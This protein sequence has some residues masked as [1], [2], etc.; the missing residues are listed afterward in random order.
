MATTGRA[1]YGAATARVSRS[2]PGGA[3]DGTPPE[4]FRAAGATWTRSLVRTA[5]A[6]AVGGPGA[7]LVPAVASLGQWTGIRALPGDACRWRGPRFPARIALT[8]DDGPHPDATPAVLD[9]LDDLG[10]RAT[11]F[12]VAAAA[13]RE[14]ELVAEIVRR[15]HAVGAHGYAHRS[16]LA[17][18]PRWIWRDLDA[19]ACAM[20]E[21]G[22]APVWYRPAYGH[23]T[24][25]TL[26]AARARGWRP[27]L[28]SAWGREWATRDPSDVA[29]R[30]AQGLSPGAIVL[31]HD[32]DRF[33]P[34]GMCDVVVEALGPIAE[35][36]DRRSLAAVTLDELVS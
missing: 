7:Q 17:R 24:T 22:V 9:R 3:P 35:A 21:L 31:L 33:G 27:V 20:T 1:R 25:A 30:V 8:F 19:T 28:W 14:R 32:S 12:L 16:H 36:L 26:V 23:V 29:G 6:I 34:R 10:L 2:K 4:V 13:L 18:S 5:A 15:G 11:F